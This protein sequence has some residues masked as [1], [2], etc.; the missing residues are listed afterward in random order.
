MPKKVTVETLKAGLEK[1]DKGVLKHGSHDAGSREYCALEFVSI[2]RCPKGKNP[3]QHMTDDPHEVEMPDLRPLNDA[4]EVWGGFQSKKADTLRTK[5]L[6]PVLV[7][8]WDWAKWS[9]KRQDRWYFNVI[10]RACTEVFADTLAKD[11][12]HSISDM[13]SAKSLVDLPLEDFDEIADQFTN[14]TVQNKLSRMQALCR[15]LI[16]EAQPKKVRRA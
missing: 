6:L 12:G 5:T 14:R 13:N 4:I 1:H 8:L 16:E 9:Q 3:Y 11:W 10:K 2:M 7:V 15:I